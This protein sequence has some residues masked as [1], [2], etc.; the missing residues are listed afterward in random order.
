MNDLYLYFPQWQ[1]SGKTNELLSGAKQIRRMLPN[2]KW[3]EVPVT[4]VEDIFIEKQI[5]GYESIKNQLE[6][7]TTLINKSS[8]DRIFTVG[9]GCD[10][11]IAPVS[12]LNQLYRGDLNVIWLDAHGDLNT[13]QS[14]PSKN[15]HGMPLRL[16]MGDGDTDLLSFVQQP[17]NYHQVFLAGVRDLDQPE[18]MYLESNHMSITDLSNGSAVNLLG[19]QLTGKNLYVHVDLDVI[20][21]ALFPHVKCPTKNGVTIDS[22]LEFIKLLKN[23]GNIVGGSVV[24]FVPSESGHTKLPSELFNLLV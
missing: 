12:Y 15:F 9:G 1:G 22:L 3:A 16:L 7:A 24:E 6:R 18:K 4:E 23:V 20:N 14:S 11:E 8:P 17:L 5:L 2:Y 10:V 21:P 13:P 19:K